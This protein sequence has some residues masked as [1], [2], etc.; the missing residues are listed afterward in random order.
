MKREVGFLNGAR[1]VAVHLHYDHAVIISGEGWLEHWRLAQSKI[2]FAR[3]FKFTLFTKVKSALV[4]GH[5]EDFA[6]ASVKELRLIHVRVLFLVIFC[7][8]GDILQTIVG[9]TLV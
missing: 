4:F 9:I 6:V 7:K 2:M 3:G 5:R 1:M 8:L